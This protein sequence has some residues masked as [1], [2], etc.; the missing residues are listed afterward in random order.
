LGQNFLLIWVAALLSAGAAEAAAK[1]VLYLTATYGYRH[2]DAIEASVDVF[3]Q[4]ARET[5]ALEVVHTEDVSR[6]SADGLRDFDAV[7]FFTSGE[8]PLSAQQKADLLAFVRDG[9]GFGGSHSATDTLYTW[10]EYGELI[11]GIFDGHPWVREAAV[12]VEDPENLIVAHVAPGFQ[13]EEEFYQFRAFSRESVRVLLTLDPRGLTPVP[14]RDLPLAWTRN[15]GKGRVF[16]SAFGHFPVSFRAIPLK[17]MLGKALL[18]LTGQIEAD[19]SPRVVTPAVSTVRVI[20]RTDDAVA[21][22]ALVAIAGERLTSG[23]SLNAAAVPLPARLAGTRVEVNGVAAALF[24]VKP[25][26]IVAQLPEALTA[27]A[28]LAVW[29]ATR[30][31]PP[32]ALRVERA[33]P[34]VV[35]GARSGDVVVLYA[36]GLNG[37]AASVTVNGR[38]AA[39]FYSG[40][41][42]GLV[43]VYQVNAILPEGT[44]APLEIVV[45]VDTA[46]SPA[47]RLG[48]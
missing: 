23:S 45:A 32:V 4:I 27:P 8:L 11:G 34:A 2:S 15:Y 16:Y 43:G 42:P 46:A 3:Q 24:S 21:P 19:A 12:D 17:T 38:A 33:A 26:Q 48:G 35:A 44:A 6:I 28:A 7:W 10:P 41:A 1:R 30:A 25:G 36:V 39:V 18:W 47:F 31:G 20:G 14:D 5:G 9:K 37:G 40:A 13:A 29:S 22:G